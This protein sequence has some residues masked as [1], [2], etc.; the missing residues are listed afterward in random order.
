MS[1]DQ[2]A[3]RTCEP[4][5]ITLRPDEKI[6]RRMGGGEGFFCSDPDCPIMGQASSAALT[7]LPIH[8]GTCNGSDDEPAA[9]DARGLRN[10]CIRC[11]VLLALKGVES[12]V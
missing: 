7:E 11:R 12:R 10:R 6:G 1:N 3:A 8:G 4:C 5:K 2:P 9:L